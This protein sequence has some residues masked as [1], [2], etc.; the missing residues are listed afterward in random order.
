[1]HRVK[2]R[3][4]AQPPVQGPACLG[5]IRSVRERGVSYSTAEGR[6]HRNRAPTMAHACTG[7]RKSASGRNRLLPPDG[8]LAREASRAIGQLEE[9]EPL[10]RVELFDDAVKRWPARG[11]LVSGTLRNAGAWAH[12]MTRVLCLLH[13]RSRI[14]AGSGLVLSSPSRCS[15]YCWMPS[16]LCPQRALTSAHA[17]RKSGWRGSRNG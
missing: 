1:M 9:A 4:G 5:D 13:R 15:S 11:R 10:L 3:H 16:M 17:L 8:G 14:A 2:T 6:P 12:C 7:A